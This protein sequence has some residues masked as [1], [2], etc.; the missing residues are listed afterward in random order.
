MISRLAGQNRT[1]ITD[2]CCRLHAGQRFF[3]LKLQF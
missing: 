3:V 2:R 1:K